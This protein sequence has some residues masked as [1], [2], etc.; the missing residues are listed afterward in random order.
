MARIVGKGLVSTYL[1]RTDT[2]FIATLILTSLSVNIP[3]TIADAV[4]ILQTYYHIERLDI[5]I[6]NAGICNHWGSSDRHGSQ[7]KFMYI[8]SEVRSIARVPQM[9]SLT[10]AYGVLKVAGNYLVKKIDSEYP[11]LIAFSTVLTDMGNR[12]ALL[13][14][15]M[16]APTTVAESS[17]QGIFKQVS[18]TF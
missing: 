18:I 11:S 1:A 17:V 3:S 2:I 4:L 14:W 6:A 8:S 10:T 7:P 16:Q 5:M 15:L 13:N 12:G 9:S